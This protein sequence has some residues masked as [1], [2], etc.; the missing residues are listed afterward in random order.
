MK[1]EEAIA[2]LD[3]LVFLAGDETHKKA[4]QHLIDIA[5]RFD[6]AVELYVPNKKVAITD[7]QIFFV[8]PETMRTHTVYAIPKENE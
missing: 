4:L 1:T 2:E 7:G 6:G 8:K 3:E 5:K